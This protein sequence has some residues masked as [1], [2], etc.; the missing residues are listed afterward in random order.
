[1]DTIGN[2]ARALATSGE[3][4]PTKRASSNLQRAL[5]DRM[6]LSEAIQ[7]ATSIIDRYP[8][9]GR[10]A[11]KGY[12]GALAATLASYPRAVATKCAD[13]KGITADSKF[14]PTVADIIAWCEAKTEPLR[15]HREREMRVQRQLTERGEFLQEQT[16][17][18]SERLTYDELK[19]KYGDGQGG[20][21]IDVEK[22]KQPGLS[23]DDLIGIVGEAEFDKIPDAKPSGNFK[24]LQ[25]QPAR[26]AAETRGLQG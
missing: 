4:S 6:I 25:S 22:R 3:G 11:G 2:A 8:N 18:R 1:M 13:L 24:P 12:I 16:A 19:A 5:D 7:A 9:G 26:E 20:W 21:G 10:D 14:L 15:L 23:R 17:D